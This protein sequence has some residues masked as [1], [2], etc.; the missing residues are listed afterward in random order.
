MIIVLAALAVYHNSFAGP[1][2]FDDTASITDNPTI[3]HLWPLW[4]SQPPPIGLTVDGRPVV[5]FTLAI[6]YALGGV[7]PWGY[8]VMNLVIH[9]LAGLTLFGI[10]R[11]TLLRPTLSGRFGAEATP[12]ALAVAVIWTVHPLQTEAVTYVVQRAE[13]LM[14]LLYLLTIYC[15]IRGVESGKPGRWYGLSLTACALGMG[16]KEVMASAPLMVLLYDSMF[17]AGSLQEAWTRRWRLYAGLAGTWVILGYLLASVGNRGGSSGFG[18]EMTWW[19]YALTQ[20]RA[21]VHYLK[22]SVWPYPL[23]FDYGTP[24]VQHVRQALPCALVLAALVGA[25]VIALWHRRAIGFLGVWFFAI[26]APSSSVVPITAQTMAEHRMYL[27]LAAVVTLGVMVINALLGRRS[28]AVFL[29]LA[30]GLGFLTIQRNQDYRTELSI[31]SDTLTKCP[32]NVRA[33]YDLGNVLLGMGKV[34]EAIDQY[35]Q[36]LQLRS[37]C[38]EAHDNLGN[39]LCRIGRVPEAIGHY[40]EALRVFPNDAKVHYNFG[41]A[42][43]QEGQLPGAIGHYEQALRSNPDFTEAHVNLGIAL[44]QIGSNQDALAHFT[45]AL[46]LSPDSPEVHDNLGLALFQAGKVQEAIDHY[47]Q[48]LRIKPD[49]VEAHFNLGLA[50]DKMGRTTEAIEHYQQ[51][52]KLR[53]DFTAA[54]NALAR[55]R[56][57][58]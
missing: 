9:I 41:R 2:I 28:G 24:T 49:Y 32:D 48:A 11:R 31:W 53:P 51:A 17:V 56:A 30:V 57:G 44:A 46:R 13:S 37:D 26:L 10:A 45:E 47:E 40:E 58:R 43:A 1:F 42:L 50:L 23:V 7:T 12:L 29:A 14:G 16:T 19:V 25:T 6:N 15:F 35:E 33:H 18:T 36:A 52:L 27:P 55:L 39:A 34:R 20:C 8:H 3:R 38:L 21:V 22:L 4:R 5:N 54:A